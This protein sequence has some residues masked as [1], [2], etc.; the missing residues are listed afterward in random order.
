MEGSFLLSSEGDISRELLSVVHNYCKWRK[1]VRGHPVL[2]LGSSHV[3]LKERV[4]DHRA[5]VGLLTEHTRSDSR[6]PVH[7]MTL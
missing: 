6:N 3:V 7:V 2:K 1:V 5:R 4:Y